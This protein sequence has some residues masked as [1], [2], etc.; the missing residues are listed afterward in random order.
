M[1][2]NC[3]GGTSVLGSWRELDLVS[4]LEAKFWARSP[5]KG[6]FWYHK[7]QK[8][9]QNPEFGELK[10]QNFGYLSRILFGGK[11]WSSV[12]NFRGKSPLL[13]S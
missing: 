9:G 7:R 2:I 12:T 3:H 13:T 4:S 5:N 1:E 8:L 6:K 11:I 10:R